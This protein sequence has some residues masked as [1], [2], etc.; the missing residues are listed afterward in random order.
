MRAFCV[1]GE[2][3]AGDLE[4]GG[5]DRSDAEPNR[6]S[7]AA[8]SSRRSASA[9][10][11]AR[12][13][14][15]SSAPPT[16]SCARRRS[17]GWPTAS[18]SSRRYSTVE[19]VETE[20]RTVSTAVALRSAGRG[21]ATADAVEAALASRPHLSGEQR[22]MV[23]R[24]TRDGDGVAVIV[25]PA[26]TG[27]TTALAAAREAWEAAGVTSA[28]LRGRP[29]GGA[30]TPPSVPGSTPPASRPCCGRSG[31]AG[32][33]H[34]RRDRRGEHARHAFVR[35]LPRDRSMRPAAKSS[36]SA[37]PGSC[38]PSRLAASSAPS[39]RV[40]R[41]R[42]ARQPPPGTALGARRRR[43]APRQRRR[44]R[45]RASTSATAGSTSEATPT[46]CSAASLAD[47][48]ATDDPDGCVMI[49]HYRA[50]VRELNGRARAVMRAAGR[51]GP[52]ELVAAAEPLRRRRPRSSSSTTAPASTS[53]TASA[54]SWK[55]ST[56]APAS[57][58]VRFDDRVVELDA[59]LPRAAQPHGGRPTLEHGYAMTAHAAQGLTCRHALVLAPRRHLPAN[60]PTPR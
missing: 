24:L 12:R 20:Q 44:G 55:R 5:A 60:G 52:D 42:A 3:A 38:R 39:P 6:P 50:D 9:R 54:A 2:D 56:S 13:C 58:S 35:G 46:T 48:H 31:S 57:L 53:A 34:R 40:S 32:A 17:C 7:A 15:S 22:A 16:R 51:L 37:T 30:G 10:A 25:G 11:R 45:A 26:G 18:E 43:A 49:A 33:R 1:S 21:V 4:A 47:W 27:K 59:E 41:D 28:R 19:L 36:S 29:Q 14:R 23:E 8:R